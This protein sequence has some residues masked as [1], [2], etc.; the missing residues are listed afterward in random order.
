[1]D[2]SPASAGDQDALASIGQLVHSLL[3]SFL[4]PPDSCCSRHQ[5]IKLADGWD[6]KTVNKWIPPNIWASHSG[7]FVGFIALLTRP[8]SV[9]GCTS[10][11]DKVN[12][13]I[14]FSCQAGVYVPWKRNKRAFKEETHT[15]TYSV[16]MNAVQQV[17]CQ[18]I[19]QRS[20]ASETLLTTG[21][22]DRRLHIFLVIWVTKK[23]ICGYR[24]YCFPEL[25]I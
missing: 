24:N 6:Y 9:C 21:N 7:C 8:V 5:R 20:S 16:R 18:D 15:H 22:P 17:I 19:V 25:L 11:F 1:M 10:G 3:M 14:L 12:I 4:P 13:F 23:F 2:Y